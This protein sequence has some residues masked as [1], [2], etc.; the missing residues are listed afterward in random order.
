MSEDDGD[1]MP[2]DGEK[3]IE[4]ARGDHAEDG[5]GAEILRMFADHRNLGRDAVDHFLD[6]SVH[7]LDGEE[8]QKQH[9]RDHHFPKGGTDGGKQDQRNR[10]EKQFLP[11][12]QLLDQAL[13]ARPGIG[14][15]GEEMA[16]TRQFAYGRF[17]QGA[18]R[19]AV[20]GGHPRRPS[21]KMQI[22]I[23]GSRRKHLS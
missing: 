3:Q 11:E 13:E 8:H 22:P 9:G 18:P 12:R 2:A 21:V 1:Q 19:L 14:S 16:H 6:R 17:G 15:S 20:I 5:E 10:S 23:P 4:P 7:R